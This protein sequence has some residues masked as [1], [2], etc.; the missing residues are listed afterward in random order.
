MREGKI[1]PNWT[2]LVQCISQSCA[3]DN[4]DL[5]DN[6][7]TPYLEEYPTKN[8]THVPRVAPENNLNFITL[9]Q[10]IKQLQ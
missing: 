3:P 10:Y 9:L 8:P 5:K 1:P 7:F 2:Y 4:I 6:F